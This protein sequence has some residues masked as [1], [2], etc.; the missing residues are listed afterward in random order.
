M[1]EQLF[2]EQ[3]QR[4]YTSYLKGVISGEPFVPIVY[5]RKIILPDTTAAAMDIFMPA[6][7]K[8]EKKER[9]PGWTIDWKIKPHKPKIFPRQKWPVKFTVTTEADY[10]YLLKKEKEVT[11]FKQQLQELLNWRSDITAW[12]AAKPERV[13]G[14]KP[15]WKEIRPVIDYIL[16]EKDLSSYYLTTLN[17]PVHTKF[18]KTYSSPI[19]SLLKHL[20]P[21]RFPKEINDIEEALGVKKAPY[22]RPVRWLDSSLAD[23]YTEKIKI[24]GLTRETLSTIDWKVSEL[25]L[26]ENKD[27]LHLLPDRKNALAIF[28]EGRGVLEADFIPTAYRHKRLFYW[29]DLDTE[30]FYILHLLKKQYPHTQSVLMDEATVVFH[31]HK[32]NIVKSHNRPVLDELNTTETVAYQLLT[33]Q[34][35][36]PALAGRIEQQQLEQQYVQTYLQQIPLAGI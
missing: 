16:A 2:M 32:I 4:R 29:G 15:V 19:L 3:L 34:S 31:Q 33:A 28:G 24:L 27:N 23:Q 22:L 25:W 6:C 30:G 26:V 8:H 18:I 14:L 36:L 20:D 17:V 10:L 35:P 12:L 5:A 21:L 7:L 9:Q 13:L 11:G 1:V